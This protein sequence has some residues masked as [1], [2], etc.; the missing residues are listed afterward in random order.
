MI[1]YKNAYITILSNINFKNC[2]QQYN[3]S[4]VNN[5][6]QKLQMIFMHIGSDHIFSININETSKLISLILH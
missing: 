1:K 2:I 6:T 4:S 3:L 5:K